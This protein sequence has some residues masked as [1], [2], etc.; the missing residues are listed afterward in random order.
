MPEIEDI[1][2][3]ADSFHP[4]HE[5]RQV[6]VFKAE[7]EE[8]NRGNLMLAIWRSIHAAIVAIHAFI[9]AIGISQN[10]ETEFHMV[11]GRIIFLYMVNKHAGIL[12]VP[13]GMPPEAFYDVFPGARYLLF[14]FSQQFQFTL[15]N[16]LLMGN[17]QY[18][19]KT[20]HERQ[21]YDFKGYPEVVNMLLNDR[22]F[23]ARTGVFRYFCRNINCRNLLSVLSGKYDYR[24]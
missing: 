10:A 9:A 2:G 24:K 1:I 17:G 22:D 7:I 15:H 19:V 20:R 5:L 18:I 16:G 8:I 14:L 3:F 11:L 13:L 12:S 23:L 4:F 6:G 21:R